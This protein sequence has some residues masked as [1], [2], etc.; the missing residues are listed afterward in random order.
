MDITP[1]YELRGR[2]KN[3]MISGCG[4]IGEDFRLKRAAQAVKPLEA[5]SPVFARIGQLMDALMAQDCDKPAELVLDAITLVDAVL[6][7]QAAS[8]VPGELREIEKADWG[9]TV[10]NAPYSALSPLL[11]ALTSSGNGRYGYV[12]ETHKSQPELFEDY[13]VKPVLVKALGASYAELADHAAQWLQESGACV[14]PL[15]KKDFDP[16]GKKEMVRR[17]QVIDSVAGEAANDFYLEELAQAEKEVRSA[18]IYGL[19]HCSDNADRLLEMVKTERGNCKKTVLHALAAMDDA[20]IRQYWQDSMEKDPAQALPYLEEADSLWASDLVA[21]G[22]KELL[23]PWCEPEADN[24]PVLT[25]EKAALIEA[26]MRALP[27]KRGSKALSCWYFAAAL[28]NH[29]DRPVEGEKAVWCLEQLSGIRLGWDPRN[30]KD[31]SFQR[32]VPC[33]LHYALVLRPDRELGKLA[34]AFY[35]TIGEPY[36]PAALT[37]QLFFAPPEEC[38]RWLE[39]QMYKKTIVGKKL[40]PSLISGLQR[41]LSL[42]SWNERDKCYEMT[43]YRYSQV[44]DRNVTVCQKVPKPLD[45]YVTNLL[46]ECKATALD[47]V[48]IRW[49]RQGDRAYCE[50]LGNYFY[51]RARTV[52]GNNSMY[53]M[54]MKLCGVTECSGLAIKY[55]KTRGTVSGW[56]AWS[57]LQQMPGTW[58]AKLKETEALCELV[59]TG[60]LKGTN[61]KERLEEF[62][63]LARTEMYQDRK[64]G[65]D[66]QTS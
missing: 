64:N 53:L 15:L 33:L 9:S 10:T 47:H 32:A 44:Q 56:E 26:Y 7:T 35:E 19:R 46:M 51:E 1:L 48:L 37:A 40:Q 20:R 23:E 50:K 42:I 24:P 63:N 13:R 25:K 2:L 36:F 22:L 31:F 62:S 21:E 3:V 45:G 12:L 39:A 55:F 29:L 60:R 6:C 66:G 54:P 49:I 30:Q 16:K 58:E 34:L 11:D 61:L 59:N 57:Y 8:E 18:L 41:G 5:A 65:N 43:R 38:D 52:A 4:L 28:G 17:V 27:G 14:L